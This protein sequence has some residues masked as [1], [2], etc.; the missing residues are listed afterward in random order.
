VINSRVQILWKVSLNDL[1]YY[2][3]AAL[4]VAR[5]HSE[6]TIDG[7]PFVCAEGDYAPNW[8]RS[9]QYAPVEFEAFDQSFDGVSTYC[10]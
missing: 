4:A 6:F 8:R 7:V 3:H 5:R 9:S 1:P 10:G 2:I